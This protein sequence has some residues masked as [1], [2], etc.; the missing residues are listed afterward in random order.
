M[1]P[2]VLIQESLIPA[3][4]DLTGVTPERVHEDRELEHE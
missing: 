1:A 4:P 2:A 3:W